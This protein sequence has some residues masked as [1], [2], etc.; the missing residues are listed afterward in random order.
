MEGVQDLNHFYSP[1]DIFL[2][3]SGGLIIL[4]TREKVVLENPEYKDRLAPYIKQL[5][6]EGKWTLLEMTVFPNFVR[7]VN[8][9]KFAFR[10]TK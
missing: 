2:D 10:V 6:A 5:E 4:L 9:V 7:N 3:I 8:G 1:S